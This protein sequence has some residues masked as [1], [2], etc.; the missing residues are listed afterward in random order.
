MRAPHTPTLPLSST[1]CSALLP[2]SAILY[3]MFRN[4][5]IT[6]VIFSLLFYFS[7]SLYRTLREPLL[8]ARINAYAHSPHTRF[9]PR[10]LTTR[11]PRIRHC[12]AAC[13]PLRTTGGK[14]RAAHTTHAFATAVLSAHTALPIHTHPLRTCHAATPHVTLHTACTHAFLPPLPV[15]VAGSRAYIPFGSLAC[16]SATCNATTLPYRGAR[17][18]YGRGSSFWHKRA[19]TKAR[20]GRERQRRG[21]NRGDKPPPPLLPVIIAFRRVVSWFSLLTC[22]FPRASLSPP[23]RCTYPLSPRYHLVLAFW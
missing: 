9:A 1:F 3:N 17:A 10:R 6:R 5:A 22:P 11:S 12:F 14:R 16:R 21:I 19:V 20:R 7:T 18:L 23:A 8:P 4:I 2:A 13:L 15:T